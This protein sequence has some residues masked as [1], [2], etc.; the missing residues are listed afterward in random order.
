MV[1]IVIQ[2]III[3][4]AFFLVVCDGG[5]LKEQ[6]RPGYGSPASR[7]RSKSRVSAPLRAPAP[8]RSS[9]I[10]SSKSRASPA[11]AAAASSRSYSKA[12]APAPY[13]RP[14]RQ[15][16]KGEGAEPQPE[17]YS[18]SFDQTDEYG[19]QWTREETGDAT[20]VVKGSYSY[21]DPDGI[22]RRVEYTADEN[23]FRAVVNTNE[24]GVISHKPADAEYIKS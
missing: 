23:G 8:P 9:P 17:P 12:R 20:G 7:V 24:P 21:R 18:F 22:W 10:R 2:L 13:V 14:A 4:I 19:T 1:L 16:A 11:R 5:G 6:G 3:C 15:T